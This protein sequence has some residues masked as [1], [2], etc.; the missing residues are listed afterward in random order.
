MKSRQQ[1]HG[2]QRKALDSADRAVEF[3]DAGRIGEATD[4]L[5]NAVEFAPDNPV[6]RFE[7]AKVY[8]CRR[9]ESGEFRSAA[10]EQCRHLVRQGEARDDALP[11]ADVYFLLASLLDD[12]RDDYEEAVVF[13]RMGLALN[14]F[15][16]VAHNNI[17]AVLA[18]LEQVDE[19]VGHFVRALELR[20]TYTRVYQNLA[21]IYF[22]WIAKE[23]ALQSA[24]QGL[25]SEHP[26]R[27]PMIIG[28]WMQALVEFARSDAWEDFYS[29]GHRMKNH[30]SILASRLKRL[31]RKVDSEELNNA[32]LSVQLDEIRT[33]VHDASAELRT[34]L[35]A[36]RPIQAALCPVDLNRVI[37]SVLEPIRASLAPGVT[38]T[39]NLTP[40][41]PRVVGNSIS[42]GEAVT[43]LAVN[44][45]DAIGD[46]GSICIE[47]SFK[48]DAAEVLV[49]VDDTGAGIPEQERAEIFRPG[50]TGKSA[51]SG[52]GLSI[53]RRTVAEIGGRVLVEDSTLGGARLI[54]RIPVVEGDSE[55]IARGL[56]ERPVTLQDTSSLLADELTD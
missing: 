11:L 3:L 17:G 12:E 19:A 20:P 21:K 44:A 34:Y 41:L 30:F 36:I 22:R 45:L 26:D 9:G 13:Y 53:V 25:I 15:F 40:Y 56:G 35:D 14:E 24:I 7:L 54:L 5:E 27:A 10:I 32:D 31:R 6:Y 16:P 46:A 2:A 23:G 42:L 49:A 39:I 29:R 47:T 33:S 8:G 28:R 38:M 51:G 37:T 18:E 50:V 4:A 43:N 55:V 1:V 52:L 48:K